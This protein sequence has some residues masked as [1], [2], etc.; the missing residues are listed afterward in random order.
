ME[1]KSMI[2]YNKNKFKK[3][4]SHK[5]IKDKVLEISKEL[6][7]Y[8]NFEDLVIISVLNGSIIVLNELLKN[9]NCNYNLDY[10]ELSSYKGGTKTSGSIDVIQDISTDITNKKVL[11]IEDIIDTG[12]TLNFIYKKLLKMSPKDVKVFSLLYKKEKYKFDI[13]IDWYGFAIKD[14][15]T[16]GY[17]MDYDFKFRGLNDIYALS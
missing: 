4:I 16:I 15:F 7:E 9:I 8:Y 10:I 5:E 17:G 2:I 13:K 11:I 1:F 6:N 14:I 3:V 12:R